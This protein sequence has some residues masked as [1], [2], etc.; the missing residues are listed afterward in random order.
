MAIP[1]V[2][3]TALVRFVV[4][5]GRASGP[6]AFA[7]TNDRTSSVL[8][9][10]RI[11]FIPFFLGFVGGVAIVDLEDAPP[12]RFGQQ[13]LFRPCEET[14]RRVRRWNAGCATL[15]GMDGG[16]YIG[17]YCSER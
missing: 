10:R 3:L 16:D 1:S 17:I 6:A 13:F 14:G 12:D 8:T 11:V 4:V 7:T 15:R 5:G 2:A 9:S